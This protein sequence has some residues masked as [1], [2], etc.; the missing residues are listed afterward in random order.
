MFSASS[1]AA[2]SP[3]WPICASSSLASDQVRSCPSSSSAPAA[4]SISCSRIRRRGIEQERPAFLHEQTSGR[5]DLVRS[6]NTV[7]VDTHGVRR[8]TLLLSPDRFDFNQPVRVV[9][10]GE[11]SHDAVVTPDVRTMLRWASADE[12]RTFLV[13]VEL[14]VAVPR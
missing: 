5:V 6:G 10:N 2:R 4:R 14:P 8:Y 1:P 13:G 11:V 12:D 7:V 9:T 3:P